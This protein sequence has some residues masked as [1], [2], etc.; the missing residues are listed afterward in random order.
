[1]LT[2]SV[3]VSIQE[4][5][6]HRIGESSVLDEQFIKLKHALRRETRYQQT[7]F[8]VQGTLDMLVSQSSARMDIDAGNDDAASGASTRKRRP[9]GDVI[10][11]AKRSKRS[12]LSTANKK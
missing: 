9:D 10:S 2:T 1:M 6:A 5:Y 7:L 12:T 4:L 3:S 11:P 8:K